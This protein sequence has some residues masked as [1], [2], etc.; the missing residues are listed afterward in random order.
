MIRAKCSGLRTPWRYY[1][2]AG[3]SLPLLFVLAA[4]VRAQS[5]AWD[6]AISKDPMTDI[7]QGIAYTKGDGTLVSFICQ[8]NGRVGFEVK[9]ARLDFEVGDSRQVTWR[10]DHDQ[11]LTET[12][13]NARSGEAIVTGDSATQIARRVAQASE[14]FVVDDGEGTAVFSVTGARQ[15]IG[16]VFQVCGIN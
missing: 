7:D 11:P 1:F 13:G 2:R 12:W 8:K 16:R 10:V 5:A 3:C 14:Q 6:T 9:T 4:P 15:A